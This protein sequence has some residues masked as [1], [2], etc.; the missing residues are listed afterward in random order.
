MCSIGSGPCA[1]CSCHL[2]FTALHWSSSFF[3]VLVPFSPVLACSCVFFS[4]LSH[5]LPFSTVLTH[6]LLFS[7]PFSPVL[8]PSCPSFS[9]H[10]PGS[11]II[12]K[13][14][15]S[16]LF[17]HIYPSSSM[18]C[19]FPLQGSLFAICS[20]PRSCSLFSRFCCCRVPLPHYHSALHY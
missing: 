12:P 19:H 16:S 15:R 9:V 2:L 6:S 14:S 11:P 17:L 7:I 13:S 20:S 5:P 4:I 8:A 18:F 3:S 1:G 10:P